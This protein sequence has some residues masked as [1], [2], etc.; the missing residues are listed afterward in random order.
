MAQSLC[1]R[2]LFSLAVR[3]C[4]AAYKIMKGQSQL[5]P[6]GTHLYSDELLPHIRTN[7]TLMSYSVVNK[8]TDKHK[9]KRV[10]TDARIQRG[11]HSWREHTQG[12]PGKHAHT[13]TQRLPGRVTSFSLQGNNSLAHARWS[14]LSAQASVLCC[15]VDSDAFFLFLLYFMNKFSD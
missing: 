14:A 8:H 15:V 11:K 5:P 13:H 6:D 1:P 4:L 2:L 10:Q 9:H 12:H 7:P 3:R